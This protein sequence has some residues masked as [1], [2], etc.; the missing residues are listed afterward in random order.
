MSLKLNLP[1]VILDPL[2]TVRWLAHHHTVHRLGLAVSCGA[3]WQI[4]HGY[5]GWKMSLAAW[6]D[7]WRHEWHECDDLRARHTV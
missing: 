7:A 5:G 2:P 4:M 1:F 3:E 6:Q